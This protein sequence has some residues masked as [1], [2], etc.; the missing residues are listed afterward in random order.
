[1]TAVKIAAVI[2]ALM[3]GATTPSTDRGS[4][5]RSVASPGGQRGVVANPQPDSATARAGSAPAKTH[6]R[7]G[8][9]SSQWQSVDESIGKG[10]PKSAAEALRPIITGAIRD[11]AW[12]EATRAVAQRIALE[13]NIQGNKPEEKIRRMQAEIAQA[14]ADMRPMMEAILGQWFWQYFRENRWR[15][16]S[17]A[18]TS[19]PPGDDFTTW[20][21]PCI[22]AE[23]DAHFMRALAASELLKRTPIEEYGDLIDRGNAPDAYRATRYDFTAHEALTFYTS[24]EQVGAQPEDAFDLPAESPVFA[25]A[26]EFVRWRVASADTGSPVFKAVRL[27]QDLL[28]FH[29]SDT[30]PT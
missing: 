16:V 22:Y 25:P 1:M 12:A 21:L 30:D 10:L 27:Y 26:E 24:G 2:V 28:R 9:R 23:I 6:Y 13:A 7:S 3:L 20:D 14:P 17:R 4:W 15:F 8:P 5:P 18:R 29:A 19:E 11:R